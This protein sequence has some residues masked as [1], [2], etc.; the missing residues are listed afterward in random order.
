MFELKID[1]NNDAFN[2][3]YYGLNSESLIMA[4]R[5]E[6]SRILRDEVIRD[7]DCQKT[8]GKCIALNGNIVG[9]WKLS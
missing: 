8:E 1:T 6:I 2:P 5:M 7:M 4:A 9:E 3:E